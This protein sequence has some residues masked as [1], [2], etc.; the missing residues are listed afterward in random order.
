[1]ELLLGDSDWGDWKWLAPTIL[2]TGSVLVNIFQALRGGRRDD[3]AALVTQYK[4]LAKQY[5]RRTSA[6][7][8]AI[9]VLEKDIALIRRQHRAEMDRSW[10]EHEKCLRRENYWRLVL[11]SYE[12]ALE[13]AG[14]PFERYSEAD[15]LG[16][17]GGVEL[18]G[19]PPPEPEGPSP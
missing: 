15:I 11:Q 17:P 13:E 9:E 16:G 1:V 3:T 18:H 5:E 14:I 19:P 7:S 2:A 12:K 10:Q 4:D 6:L 8:R